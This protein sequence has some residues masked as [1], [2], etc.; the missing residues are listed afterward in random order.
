LASL[1]RPPF[2]RRWRGSPLAEVE[3]ETS[4]LWRPAE[5]LSTRRMLTT[6][7]FDHGRPGREGDRTSPRR[8]ERALTKYSIQRQRMNF[9]G[10]FPTARGRTTIRLRTIGKGLGLRVSATMPDDILKLMSLFPQPTRTQ[11]SVEYQPVPRTRR[12]APSGLSGRERRR[13]LVD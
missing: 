7:A 11:P 8:S 4:A 9:P 10:F 6:G 12:P 3:D 5:S 13:D 1:P 2:S